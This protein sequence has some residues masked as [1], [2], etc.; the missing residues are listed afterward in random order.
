MYTRDA[1]VGPVPGFRAS[2]AA[3]ADRQSRGVNALTGHGTRGTRK[4][5]ARSLCSVSAVRRAETGA[6][7]S[8][9]L[10]ISP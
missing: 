3:R 8:P 5:A 6:S 7:S 4:P 1:V 2:P 9:W 10:L